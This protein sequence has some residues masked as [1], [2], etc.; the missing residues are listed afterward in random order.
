MSLCLSD[1][2]DHSFFCSCGAC[3]NDCSRFARIP[4]E[5]SPVVS[6]ILWLSYSIDLELVAAVAISTLF[7]NLFLR[8]SPIAAH[9]QMIFLASQRKL[10][11]LAL[12]LLSAANCGYRVPMS[13]NICL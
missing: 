4:D 3:P 8:F 11:I 2:V 1:N 5:F 13:R 10:T 9:I 6:C 7:P 12:F